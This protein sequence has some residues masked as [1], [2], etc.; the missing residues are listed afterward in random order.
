MILR[1][2]ATGSNQYDLN[3]Q[4][5][6]SDANGVLG[7]LKTEQTT[8]VTNATVGGSNIIYGYFSAVR[9]IRKKSAKQWIII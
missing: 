2:E 7:S 5:Y 4:I 1:V 3:F 8:T 9:P 6:N